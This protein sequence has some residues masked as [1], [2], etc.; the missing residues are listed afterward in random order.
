MNGS[1]IYHNNTK[2]L[3][4]EVEDISTTLVGYVC[5]I[6]SN[7]ICRSSLTRVFHVLWIEEG[8]IDGSQ[9]EAHIQNIGR[10]KGSRHTWVK[11]VFLLVRK[12][13]MEFVKK[14]YKDCTIESHLLLFIEG[15]E[16]T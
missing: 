11:A 7:T 3:V 4:S 16:W 5:S 2:R 14:T 8:F 6:S 1:S 13:E 10:R 15:N 12:V 9:F